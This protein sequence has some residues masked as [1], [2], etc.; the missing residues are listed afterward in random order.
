M[1]IEQERGL[2][3]GM[4]FNSRICVPTVEVEDYRLFKQFLRDQHMDYNYFHVFGSNF[5][6]HP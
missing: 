4:S 5:A 3:Q 1:V 2:S 6:P